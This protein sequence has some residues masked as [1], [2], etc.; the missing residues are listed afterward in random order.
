[1]HSAI[2]FYQFSVCA[3]IVFKRMGVLSD[4]LTVWWGIILVLGT[5]CCYKIPRELPRR[6]FK[7]TGSG[8]FCFAIITLYIGNDTIYV[9][10]EH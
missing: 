9:T 1:M 6:G 2:L 5:N 4:F 10:V 7:Y 3:G 8:K